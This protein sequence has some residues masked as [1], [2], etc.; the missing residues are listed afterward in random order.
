MIQKKK[1]KIQKRQKYLA[2][3]HAL[4]HKLNTHE[5]PVFNTQ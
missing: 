5:K 4:Q 1:K 2:A 3:W